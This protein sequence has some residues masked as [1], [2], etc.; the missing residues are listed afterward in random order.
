VRGAKVRGAR[1]RRASVLGAVLAAAV[2]VSAQTLND[3]RFTSATIVPVAS[4]G[5]TV[6]RMPG[7]TEV[8]ARSATAVALIRYAY[9]LSD[10][11][12]LGAPP[13]A[14]TERYELRAKAPVESSADHLKEM[15]RVLLAERFHLE[16]HRDRW[17]KTLVIDRLERPTTD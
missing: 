6:I 1:V 10:A 3:R 2:A 15:M 4:T 11:E 13:W 5:K 14:V 17:G 16:A 12:V 7:N 9:E 8:L